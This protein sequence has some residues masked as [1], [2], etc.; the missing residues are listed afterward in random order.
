MID[1]KGQ[2]MQLIERTAQRYRNQGYS[3]DIRPSNLEI[4]LDNYQPDLLAISPEKDKKYVIEVKKRATKSSTN[5]LR[6]IANLVKKYK[7]WQFIL[8]TGDDVLRNRPEDNTDIH[9]LSVEEVRHLWRAS[10]ELESVPRAKFMLLWSV[11]E[12]LARHQAN[13][14][15]LPFE[16]SQVY[17]LIKQ[18]YSQGELLVGQEEQLQSIL[19][20]RNKVIHGFQV[21]QNILDEANN[22]LYD[23]IS[24]L[25]E[26]WYQEPS[27]SF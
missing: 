4:D 19:N 9:L 12:S 27:P 26:D 21:E 6:K 1:I 8:V 10:N 13:T 23:L 15:D 20:I 24:T 16:Q 22:N 17:V 2:E 25:F 14:I 18:L 7:G 5:Q 3:V 11:F